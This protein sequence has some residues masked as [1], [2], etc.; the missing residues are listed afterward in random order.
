MKN[1]NIVK[2]L[3]IC[4]LLVV[5]HCASEPETTTTTENTNNTDTTSTTDN[6][7]TT[8]TTTTTTAATGVCIVS[9]VTG[10]SNC[11][12]ESGIKYCMN[13]VP[14]ADCNNLAVFTCDGSF[15]IGGMLSKD[16]FGAN[17]TCSSNS[18]SWYDPCTA[19]SESFDFIING[20]NY[21]VTSCGY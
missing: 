20:T 4:I 8:T 7:T 5:G 21:S 9:G 2:L 3:V 19:N 1:K 12:T 6:T 10:D 16:Y 11:P 18:S 15:S 14:E 13:N 17:E